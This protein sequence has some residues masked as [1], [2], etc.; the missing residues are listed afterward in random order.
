RGDA[1]LGLAHAG[2]VATTGFAHSAGAWDGGSAAG[3]G[4][5]AARTALALAGA[6]LVLPRPVRRVLPAGARLPPAQR[7]HFAGAG[8]AGDA[9]LGVVPPPPDTGRRRRGGDD[10]SGFHGGGALVPLHLCL[11]A[12]GAG[13]TQFLPSQLAGLPRTECV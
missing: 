4:A 5:G 3:A 9:G 1:G 8:L 6:G 10:G 12:T 2:A 11:R 13:G 7:S